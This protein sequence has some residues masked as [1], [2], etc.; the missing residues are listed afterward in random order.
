MNW[1]FG[2]SKVAQIRARAWSWNAGGRARGRQCG[3]FIEKGTP[4]L[5][6]LRR[7][8]RDRRD[9]EGHFHF[10]PVRKRLITACICH[11]V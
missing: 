10:Q 7:A 9:L 2:E 8:P 6:F 1:T 4:H 11:R 5:T 3:E